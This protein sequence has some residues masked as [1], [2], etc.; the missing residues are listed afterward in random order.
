M[1]CGKANWKREEV[2][3]H[4]FDFIDV[5]DFRNNGCFM[6]LKY[7]FLFVMVVKSFAVYVADIYTAVT[8][9]AFGHFSGSL[10][11]KVQNDP[12]NNFR[13]PI[14]Y[15]RWIFS[16]CIIFSFLL[17]AYEAHKSRAIVKSRDI[18]YAFTNVMANNYYSLRSYDHYCF[19]D[20]INDSKKKKDELAFWIFFTF[21]GWK[22][23]LVADGP[24]QVINFFTLYGLGSFAKWSTNPSDYYEGNIFTGIMILSMLF[25]VAV[26]AGSMILLM[27]AGI[28]Y[29]PLL[30]YIKG[31]L[32]EYCCHK[33]DKRVTELVHLKK[34]QRL[35]KVN[36]IARKEAAGDFSHLM[37]KKG[38]MVRQAIPQPTLPTVDV[39]L[40]NDEK[41]NRSGPMQRSGSMA[42]SL[43][44]HGNG[45]YYGNH[46]VPGYQSPG[47]GPQHFYGVKAPSTHSLRYDDNGEYASTANLVSNAGP[48]GGEYGGMSSNTFDSMA[49]RMGPIGTS[50]MLF[51]QRVGGGGGGRI[52]PAP[53][54]SQQA[55]DM[56]YTHGP[57]QQ[58]SL[59]DGSNGGMSQ[60]AA[61]NG[62]QYDMQGRQSPHPGAAGQQ[63]DS[64]Y[65]ARGLD[66][67]PPQN[68]H[69]VD[70]LDYPPPQ[71]PDLSSYV[72]YAGGD[73]RDYPP[74][75]VEVTMA[76]SPQMY[77]GNSSHLVIGQ[78]TDGFGRELDPNRYSRSNGA[79]SGANSSS[80]SPGTSFNGLDDVYDA[81]LNSDGH[82]PVITPDQRHSYMMSDYPSSNGAGDYQK[83]D[84]H[85]DTSMS[86]NGGYDS[87]FDSYRNGATEPWSYQSQMSDYPSE[88][89]PQHDS[90]Q[91]A[92]T[93]RH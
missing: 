41:P 29:I 30:C 35:A 6:Q 74:P 38:E 90:Y 63:Q 1:C 73:A 82:S 33:V 16:G 31:N 27:M 50:P 19:F 47:H 78:G 77:Q 25:T 69:G 12:D 14:S 46:G 23:L 84:A 70:G 57:G 49:D 71:A 20:H 11:D 64:P 8:L 72:P 9:L 32:K 22:R 24:R 10:Y 51:A 37:N 66:Y 15:G 92:Q 56:Y 62:G 59:L 65:T 3:D 2:P 7:V 68:T 54:A 42:S 45:G 86:S 52:S 44:A 93:P 76:G 58:R 67:P 91:H 89:Y 36:E 48:A 87:R 60:H 26:F 55:M 5:R 28:A 13:V 4:K 40:L 53:P 79:G 75:A 21:K 61:S 17:L 88:R 80:H 83:G 39:D 81:Y 34:R 85:H 43:A 18:S